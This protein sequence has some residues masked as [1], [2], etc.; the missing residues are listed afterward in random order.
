MNRSACPDELPGGVVVALQSLPGGAGLPVERRHLMEESRRFAASMRRVE[1]RNIPDQAMAEMWL[2]LAHLIVNDGC[3]AATTGSSYGRTVGRYLEW[4]ANNGIDFA[5]VTINELDRWQR[6]LAIECRNKENWRS[7][8]VRAVRNFYD[9][10]R[11]RGLADT[12][13]AADLRGPRIKPKPA[14]KYTDDQLRALF[15]AITTTPGDGAVRDL[16]IVLLWLSTGAR[17]EE[18]STLTLGQLELQRRVGVV[19]FHGKGS[20]DR[21]VPFEGPVVDAL[22]GWLQVREA[23]PRAQQTDRVFFSL[24]TEGEAGGLGLRTYAYIVAKYA[25]RAGLR[26]WGIH[27]F[28]VTFA[29]QLYDDGTDI[30]TIRALMGHESIETTRRYLAVSERARKTRLSADRQH[31]VLG[32]KPTGIPL[33]ARRLHGG[34]DD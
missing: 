8:Q 20:K 11:S 33:W 31:R 23:H 27:R 18:V 1:K 9:W 30:E 15:R 22:H 13:L 28:R 25:K 2:W 17:R 3:R 14:K 32:T 4:A 5:A 21:D 34:H 10:R 16:A 29:T 19:R 7:Q 24:G 26:E 6:W 12:H